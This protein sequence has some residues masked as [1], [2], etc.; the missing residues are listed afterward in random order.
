MAPPDRQGSLTNTLIW[1]CTLLAIGAL[2]V[3]KFDIWPITSI[4]TN[5]GILGPQEVAT[6]SIPV[7]PITVAGGHGG[8]DDATIIEK[9]ENST[10]DA[11]VP[12]ELAKLQLTASLPPLPRPA[13][14]EWTGPAPDDESESDSSDATYLPTGADF[15]GGGPFPAAKRPPSAA[16]EQLKPV[17]GGNPDLRPAGEDEPTTDG[18]GN[19]FTN[20]VASA[21]EVPVRSPVNSA[22]FHDETSGEIRLA[23]IDADI[24][25]G[26]DLAAHRAL[27]QIYWDE[28]KRRSAIQ[29][30]IDN[31]ARRIYFEPA[32]H[33]MEA[34][35]VEPGQT[36]AEIARQYKVSPEYLARLNHIDESAEL[37]PGT[38]LKVVMGPFA[39]VID[40]SEKCLILHAHGYY[41]RA[42][43]GEFTLENVAAGSTLLVVAES[44]QKIMFSG[45][46]SGDAGSGGN[47]FADDFPRATVRLSE[48]DAAIARDLLGSGAKV[49]VR[50]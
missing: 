4:V 19:P 8:T 50:D 20:A 26:R 35:D 27:S 36:L 22:L 45:L 29:D 2:T 31:T 28:P 11:A 30:R 49:S 46:G 12:A 24:T 32:P 41:V 34:H 39:A 38:K 9:T 7:D 47:P 1:S 15:G 37:K 44:G 3:W 13:S 48:E 33:Y 23:S 14:A 18:N 16:P 21:S 40:R 42:M 6:D 17:P 5:T 10:D 43:P 25:A